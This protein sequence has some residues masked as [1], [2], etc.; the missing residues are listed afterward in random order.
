MSGSL[1]TGCP[2]R[3]SGGLWVFAPRSGFSQL[4]TSFFASESLGIPHAPLCLF[5]YSFFHTTMMACIISGG[6]FYGYD[7]RLVLLP[8]VTARRLCFLAPTA[9]ALV[10]L[11]FVSRFLA[12]TGIY[13]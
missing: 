3:I 6:L 12:G 1:P 10:A 11:L 8:C 7:F 4:V 13:D 2:I 5:R 9:G